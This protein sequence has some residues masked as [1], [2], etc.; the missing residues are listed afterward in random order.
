M[1]AAYDY[2][3]FTLGRGRAAWQAF[4]TSVNGPANEGVVRVGGELV[5]LFA[6][7]L[8]FASDTA[9]VLV[10][11]PVGERGSIVALTGADGV[12]ARLGPGEGDRL[13]P[14]RL[15]GHV[16]PPRQTAQLSRQFPGVGKVGHD[17]ARAG[18]R[19]RSRRRLADAARCAGDQR[20]APL[21]LAHAPSFST[22][23]RT[24]P[25]SG[26]SIPG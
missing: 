1:A 4:A 25:G 10:R 26:S 6:P 9:A 18:R 23:A 11:W 2:L 21:K 7:Q 16:L 8:G 5:G 24:G 14:L 22:L 3:T 12:D 20:H 19:Q 15:V 17:H 13:G